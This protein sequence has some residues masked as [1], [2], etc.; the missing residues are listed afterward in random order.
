MKRRTKYIIA[1]GI[2]V[3]VGII[4]FALDPMSNRFMPKCIF[5]ELTGWQ[6]P[7]CGSQR[8][9]H[10]ILHGNV[11]E[12]WHHNALLLILLPM[13]IPM[14]WLEINRKRYP[15]VY[16]RVHSIPVVLTAVTVILLWWVFRN[17]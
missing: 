6:C 4:Y 13:L 8:M 12:A 2:V 11:K 14:A 5:H 17:V 10:A 9:L 16:M 1:V 7:G 15:K 3:I